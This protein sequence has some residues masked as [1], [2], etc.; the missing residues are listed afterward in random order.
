MM[1]LAVSE[2]D[3]A[4]AD[5]LVAKVGKDYADSAMFA[6]VHG[7]SALTRR[8]LSEAKGAAPF[9]EV[10]SASWEVGWLG[11][12]ELAEPFARA[13]AAR[14]EQPERGNLLLAA[15]LIS[16][17][18]WT[19][20]D[21]AFAAAAATT[22][23]PRPRI[24]QGLMASLPF[25]AVPRPE[26]EAIRT[27]LAAPGPPATGAGSAL[28]PA[29]RSYALGLLASRLGDGPGA[30]RAADQLDTMQVTAD[31]R[32]ALR[33][34]AAVVR[35]DVAL[36]SRRP[37]EALTLLENVRGEVPLELSGNASFGEDYGR[38][39]RAEALLATGNDGEA[40]RWLENGFD[41][42]PDEWIFR[43]QVALRLGDVYERRGERQK[44]VDA[45]SRFIQLWKR[46]DARL[47]P[48]VDEA[49]ARLARLTAEPRS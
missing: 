42:T 2:D 14:P 11:R 18:R 22:A 4:R 38:F 10:G 21:S 1:H 35:A 8:L 15:N 25:L 36:A 24:A 16:Q 3:I 44:A 23:D 30:L 17:G 29:L 9:G 6:I 28:V 39:L 49:R 33:A 13:A 41:A 20:A 7:D 12:P 34:L 46:C 19:A 45:Y 40:L 32:A 43:A 27:E 47:R 37:A 31:D 48:A 5:S 26:L